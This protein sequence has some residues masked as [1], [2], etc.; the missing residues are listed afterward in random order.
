MKAPL[1]AFIFSGAREYAMRVARRHARYDG[2]TLV[3]LIVILVILAVLGSIAAPRFFDRQVFA[4]RG[5]YEELAAALGHARKVAVASGCPVRLTLDATGYEARQQQASAG[6]CD[7][8]GA[9]S[10][11]VVL[12]DGR[13]L[14]A[15]APAGVVTAP[16]TTVT[17]DALGRT[18]LAT[19]RTITVGAWSLTV[20]A[21]S[22]YVEAD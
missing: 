8:G 10:V 13:P 6:R 3:E 21:T 17:F 19:D 16:A 14:A 7:P 20:Q 4:E 22:G 5:W 1:G 2:F 18:D 12:A 11:P 15:S 9:W